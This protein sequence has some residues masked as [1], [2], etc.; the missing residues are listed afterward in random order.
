MSD[1]VVGHHPTMPS[2]GKTVQAVIATRRLKDSSHAFMMT[3]L[4]RLCKTMAR[5]V[6]PS[7][8]IRR[9]P[10]SMT[11]ALSRGVYRWVLRVNH[12]AT[13]RLILRIAG[14]PLN[15]ALDQPANSNSSPLGRAKLHCARPFCCGSP[16][17]VGRYAYDAAF[18]VRSPLPTSPWTTT[19]VQPI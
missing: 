10:L 13:R 14:K 5:R 12:A 1:H 3:I 11:P 2:V 4:S 15:L 9:G 19:P 6:P 7:H 17:S 16:Q 8:A 18:K